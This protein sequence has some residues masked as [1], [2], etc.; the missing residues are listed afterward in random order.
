MTTMK[1][2]IRAASEGDWVHTLTRVGTEQDLK[3]RNRDSSMEILLV[4]AR[5][6]SGKIEISFIL[7]YCILQLYFL[8]KTSSPRRGVACVIISFYEETARPPVE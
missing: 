7:E 6:E 5:R 2:E 1:E 4:V 8:Q 3:G